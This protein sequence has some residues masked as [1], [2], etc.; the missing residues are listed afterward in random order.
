[1]S[2]LLTKRFLEI[3]KCEEDSERFRLLAK[4]NPD[5]AERNMNM[6]KILAQTAFRLR[7]SPMPP[8]KRGP[9]HANPAVFRPVARSLGR[10]HT[11]LA[12]NN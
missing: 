6:A 3:N 1:M 9:N 5:S 10:N 4:D 12:Q 8:S 7:N 11:Q 2:Q